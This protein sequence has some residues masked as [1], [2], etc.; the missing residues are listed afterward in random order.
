[1]SAV[2]FRPEP[3]FSYFDFNLI[4]LAALGCLS[5]SSFSG[6]KSFAIEAND[7]ESRRARLRCA[8]LALCSA[9]K[10]ATGAFYCGHNRATFSLRRSLSPFGGDFRLRRSVRLRR[11][12]SAGPFLFFVFFYAAEVG[13]LAGFVCY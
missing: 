9:L 5:F 2:Q 3:P 8:R 11:F 12:F 7:F 1:M 6:P 10:R 13:F 4:C